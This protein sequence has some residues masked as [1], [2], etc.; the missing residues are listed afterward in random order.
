MLQ[1]MRVTRLRTS[2][3][4]QLALSPHSQLCFVLCDP[5]NGVDGR[6]DR[7][8]LATVLCQ[9]SEFRALDQATQE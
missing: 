8:F 9:F 2:A 5:L 6:L 3:A 7:H 4:R 1:Q